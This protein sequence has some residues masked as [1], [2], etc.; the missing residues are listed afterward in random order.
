MNLRTLT[1]GALRLLHASNWPHLLLL[2][3]LPAA[4]WALRGWP[5]E[6]TL[7]LV[8]LAA[9]A[10]LML[11]ER[12]WPLSP[13]WQARRPELARDAAFLGLNAVVDSLSAFLLTA[14]VLRWAPGQADSPGALATLPAVVA[15]PLAIAI[16]E[17]GPFALHRWAHRREGLWRFHALHHQPAKLNAAN[18]V[19][20]HPLNAAWNQAARLLPW[21][22]LGFSAEVMLWAALFMQVQGLA[23]HANLRG[24]LGPLNCLIGSAELHRWHHSVVEAEAH[25]Y[26]TAIPLWDQLFGSFVYRPGRAPARLG[27]FASTAPQTWLPACCRG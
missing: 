5:H 9:L 7:A 15:L 13:D 27:L 20:A 6:Q 24:S 17:L 22:L 19:L 25:N 26:G 2:A 10:W 8:G 1:Q 18:A 14:L 4:A 23:V 21:L 16:G 3:A 11:A 12:L